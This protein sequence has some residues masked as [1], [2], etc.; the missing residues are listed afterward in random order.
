MHHSESSGESRR[1]SHPSVFAGRRGSGV[2][3]PSDE[4]Q[5]AALISN[6]A[7]SGSSSPGPHHHPP[8]SLNVQSIATQ[9]K[10]K[11]GFQIT[12]VLPAQ[13]SASGNNSIAD[14]TESYD[15]MDESHTEDLSS[16]DILDRTAD[17]GVPVR[18]SSEETL[19]SLHGGE[20]PGVTSPNEPLLHQGYMV[21]GVHHH[22]TP[23]GRATTIPAVPSGSVLIETG[24]SAAAPENVTAVPPT[25]TASR[26]RVVKLDSNS[27][28]F[29]KGRWTCAEYYEKDA[30][31]G[32]AAAHR[33]VESVMQAE[34]ES[35][36]SSSSGSTLS[37]GGDAHA[38]HPL[39][40]PP[41]SVLM[42]SVSVPRPPAHTKP[43]APAVSLAPPEYAVMPPVSPRA[44]GLPPAPVS[45]RPQ[46]F[47][48]EPPL[49]S[50]VAP[51]RAMFPAAYVTASQLED[52]HRLL[53]QHHSLLSLTAGG[54]AVPD[55]TVAL[56]PDGAAAAFAGSTGA[57]EDSSS[58]ASVVAIDNKIE[59]AMDLVKSHLM[60]AV[61]EEVEVL[62]EQIKE[63]VEKNSQL[64]QENTLLKNLASPEQLAQ[65]QAQ[66]QSGS[67]TSGATPDLTPNPG[68]G[69]TA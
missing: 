60:Y 34:L 24:V 1:M 19:N 39:E 57:D 56:G 21:N 53:L 35:T 43:P 42:E 5:T 38:S 29:R 15:D 13:V 69:A 14:D 41:A 47:P 51:L 30:P 23:Q 11:S 48:A 31:P 3:V 45:P 8:H 44:A 22:K 16:S 6:P 63:L 33:A 65:F 4:H 9:G 18:S 58:G 46:T 7:A 50:T 52:A 64:E 12:S 32:D 25:S 55:A 66:V 36:S 49:S 2:A 68:P 28:P 27:E 20:T 26:F 54:F 10:K 17:T 37:G 40:P 59:Q 62:K 67:P 61:R